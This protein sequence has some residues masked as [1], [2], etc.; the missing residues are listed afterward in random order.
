VVLGC[1]LR[2][3]PFAYLISPSCPFKRRLRPPRRVACHFAASLLSDFPRRLDR[4]FL[5]VTRCVICFCPIVLAFLHRLRCFQKDAASFHV[6]SFTSSSP[7]RGK[8]CVCCLTRTGIHCLYVL[9][10]DP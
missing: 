3:V 6:K 9:L 8:F 10:K 1:G 5:I 2:F 7:S 4:I